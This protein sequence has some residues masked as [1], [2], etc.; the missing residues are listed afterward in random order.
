M[1][2]LTQLV[3]ERGRTGPRQITPVG[4]GLLRTTLSYLITVHLSMF[5]HLPS[6][7]H[8]IPS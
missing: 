6:T 8:T 7:Y 5:Y 2:T 1:K 4:P 3:K